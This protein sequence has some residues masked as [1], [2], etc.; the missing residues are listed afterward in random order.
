[1]TRDT[2]TIT[3]YSA[4]AQSIANDFLLGVLPLIQQWASDDWHVKSVLIV[5]LIPSPGV[6]IENRLAGGEGFQGGDSLPSFCAGL[7]SFRT[8]ISGRSAHGRLYL[9]GVPEDLVSESRLEGVSLGQLQA[10]GTQ[11]VTR[12]GVAGTFANA[13]YGVFSRRL[14]VTRDP[15]PPPRLVYSTA[16]FFTV[17]SSIARPE[18]ATIRKRKLA[19]GQ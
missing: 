10:I 12:Y 11:L 5:T 19:R 4:E 15:G 18:V 16:G 3:T 13:R 2:S 17:N 1:M 6:L 7:L 8:G 14:G 9:P